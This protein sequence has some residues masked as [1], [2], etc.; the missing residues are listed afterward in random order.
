L[1]QKEV[2]FS[3][4]KVAEVL[5]PDSM[6]SYAIELLEAVIENDDYYSYGPTKEC[7]LNIMTLF[8]AKGSEYDIVIHLDLYE[9]VLPSRNRSS[10]Q[11]VQ[12]LNL[13]YVGITRARK[14]CVLLLGDKITHNGLEIEAIDSEFLWNGTISDLRDG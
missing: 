13:H 8:K 10:T 6:N 7:D 11:Y 1:I 2:I 5:A 9:G 14:A 12:D 4:V 3:F